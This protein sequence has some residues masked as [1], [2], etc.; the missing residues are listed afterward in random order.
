MPEK[1]HFNQLGAE[2]VYLM[3][4]AE[5]EKK[6]LTILRDES[7]EKEGI[8]E[9]LRKAFYPEKVKASFFHQENTKDPE[10]R[11]LRPNG[12]ERTLL[13]HVTKEILKRRPQMWHLYNTET[14]EDEEFI[15]RSGMG[16]F[17]HMN[18]EKKM[19][20]IITCGGV[21]DGKSTL[22]G[23]LLYDS[24]TAEAQ[25]KIKEDSYVLRSDGTVDYA[26]LSAWTKEEAEQGITVTVSYSLFESKSRSFYMADTPG[27]E[28]YTKFMAYAASKT[29][30]AIIMIAA[31][32]GIVPQTRR[33]TRICSFMGIRRYVFA[34][35]KMDLMDYDSQVFLQICNEILDMMQEY[36]DCIIR[37]IPVAAKKGENICQKSEHMRWYNGD[38]LL[39]TLE[40]IP[41]DDSPR[42]DLI[43]CVQRICKSSQMEGNLI[44]NRTIQGE[45][46]S[47]ILREGRQV[48]VYPAMEEVRIRN[49]HVMGQKAETAGPGEAVSF[50]LDR[51]V[52]ISRGS[53]IADIK[54]I[55]IE[56]YIQAD[57][58]WMADVRLKPGNRYI[59]KAGTRRVVASLIKICY[60]TDVNTGEHVQTGYL[61]KNA[62]AKCE[63]SLQE[64]IPLACIKDYPELGS[65]LLIDRVSAQTAASGNITHAGMPDN[66][67]QEGRIVTRQQR[68]EC[69][70]QKAY[71]LLFEEGAAS[72][73]LM[74]RMEQRLMRMGFHTMQLSG[75]MSR[76]A[77]HTIKVLFDAGIVVL[78]SAPEELQKIIMEDTYFEHR[79]LDLSKLKDN[80][81]KIKERLR[82]IQE[83]LLNET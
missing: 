65:F 33:H 13:F 46:A 67:E 39:E 12:Q 23:R 25:E 17:P 36:P 79:Q 61:T 70:G 64:K 44:R 15:I 22:I 30:T 69:L 6:H 40:Q 21:D 41:M 18:R 63:F 5:A 43:F 45:P 32:K 19:Y 37:M 77:E 72:G 80:D 9:L 47:G 71:V 14:A 28:E 76:K 31:D 60:Q 53:I 3:R 81:I 54:D 73:P 27:H 20:K 55:P 34:V 58:L 26:M 62:L 8:E 2:A 56:D 48:M 74:N 82:R 52:D 50:E 78:L 24:A 66:W 68:E 1:D 51:E 75:E 4:E 49:L 7:E 59:L 42:D 38:T 16:F 10:H 35:N 11:G 83:R 57:I 29:Q